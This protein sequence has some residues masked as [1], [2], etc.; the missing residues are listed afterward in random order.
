MLLPPEQQEIYDTFVSILNYS[1]DQETAVRILANNRWELEP[2]ILQYVEQ[3]SQYYNNLNE[4]SN[5]TA[6]ERN[7]TI[8][9]DGYDST[10]G[11][12]NNN[13]NNIN[14]VT[15]NASTALLSLASGVRSWWH[16]ITNSGDDGYASLPGAFPNSN[17]NTNA[18]Q[19]SINGSFEAIRSRTVKSFLFLV[20][21]P[22]L[23]S[24]KAIAITVAII[25]KSYRN[26]D[27]LKTKITYLNK[28]ASNGHSYNALLGPRKTQKRINPID[29][30]RQFLED[31]DNDIQRIVS[32]N[33]ID[34]ESSISSSYQQ[35]HNGQPALSRPDFLVGGYTQALYIAKRDAKWLLVYIQSDEHPDKDKFIERIFMNPCFNKF[36]SDNNILIWGGNTH[37]SEAYQAANTLNCV[38][39]PFLAL[40]CL[41][42]ELTPTSTGTESSSPVLSVVCR[43]QGYHPLNK[44]LMKFNQQ[45]EKYEP[46]LITMRNDLKEQQLARMIREQQDLAYERSLLADRLKKQKQIYRQ[47]REALM[48]QFILYKLTKLDIANNFKIGLNSDD[49]KKQYARVAIRLP[50]N[51]ARI[52]KNIKKTVSV[53]DLF[54]FT[55]LLLK[56]IIDPITNAIQYDNLNEFLNRNEFGRIRNQQHYNISSTRPLPHVEFAPGIYKH[57]FKFKI[58][59]SFPKEELVDDDDITI[60]EVKFIYPNG[61]LIVEETSEDDGDDDDDDDSDDL[62]R[63]EAV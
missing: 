39:F 58:F 33:N 45:I 32:S 37:Q 42:T 22:I 10:A 20:S 60:G 8:S 7:Q 27:N 56:E 50:N 55:E 30:S 15:V 51:S 38:R 34:L 19:F 2:A 1:G 6:S 26:L 5:I 46:M 57:K 62:S 23:L 29:T 43:V 3:D 59:S 54:I 48:K 41:T 49:D 40:L 52:I 61:N 31:F 12:N 28:H 9:D 63:L 11:I 18:S 13:N 47:R 21:L 14:D 35:Q 4:T 44:I 36:I 17:N 16:R 24:Y 25:S 53:Q